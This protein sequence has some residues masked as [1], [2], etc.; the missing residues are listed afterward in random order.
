MTDIRRMTRS[1][2][3]QGIGELK[4]AKVADF[5]VHLHQCACYQNTTFGLGELWTSEQYLNFNQTDF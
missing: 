1:F 2:L 3:R 5:K 4:V